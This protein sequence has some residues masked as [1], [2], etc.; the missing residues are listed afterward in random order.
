M[1]GISDRPS[2]MKISLIGTW[3]ILSKNNSDTGN[4]AKIKWWNPNFLITQSV[5]NEFIY[6]FILAILYY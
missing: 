3:A 5:K 1:E 2:G 4:N 6:M